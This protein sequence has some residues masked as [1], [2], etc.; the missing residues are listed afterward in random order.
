LYLVRIS[1]TWLRCPA[2]A[3][4]VERS[5]DNSSDDDGE[6]SS[7][8]ARRGGGGDDDGFGHG[9]GGADESKDLLLDISVAL[10]NGHVM[11]FKFR[12][13]GSNSRKGRPLRISSLER[14][15]QQGSDE[16]KKKLWRGFKVGVCGVKVKGPVFMWGM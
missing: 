15:G 16:S 3:L 12:G 13:G 9:Y 7:E 8:E 11:M 6:G 10:E 2:R 14:G 5:L 4:S 1:W